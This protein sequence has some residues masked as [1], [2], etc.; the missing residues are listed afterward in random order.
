MATLEDFFWY[1]LTGIFNNQC[2]KCSMLLP[3][4]SHLSEWNGLLL[5]LLIFILF[6]FR[7]EVNFCMTI[8]ETIKIILQ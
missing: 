8:F 2:I 4:S 6:Y 3:S 1:C 5:P 7:Y